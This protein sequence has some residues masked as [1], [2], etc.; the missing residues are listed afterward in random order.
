MDQCVK[1]RIM[2]S[3]QSLFLQ[4]FMAVSA[5]QTIECSCFFHIDLIF[6]LEAPSVYTFSQWSAGGVEGG[7]SSGQGYKTIYSGIHCQGMICLQKAF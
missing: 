4:P 5:G 1:V 3:S 6:K 7:G 2:R